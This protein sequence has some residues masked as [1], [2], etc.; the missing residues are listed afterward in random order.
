MAV[1]SCGCLSLSGLVWTFKLQP[2]KHT[3]TNIW[4]FRHWPVHLETSIRL[5]RT[6]KVKCYIKLISLF[7]VYRYSYT[8][9]HHGVIT[10]LSQLC[11]KVLITRYTAGHMCVNAHACTQ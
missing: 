7:Y 6:I 4:M 9:K 8:H 11:R 2:S 1:I 3:E 5:N 10:E